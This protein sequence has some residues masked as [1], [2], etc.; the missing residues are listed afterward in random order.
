M[1]VLPVTAVVSRR[2]VAG[3]E[4][5]LEEWAR[6]IVSAA[7][8]FPGHLGAQI[9]PPG[10]ERDDLV[11]AFSFASADD[12]SAWERSEVRLAWVRRADG[13]VAGPATTHALSGLESIFAAPLR[14]A[15]PPPRWKT[16]VVIALALYPAS[17]VLSWL[18]APR[19]AD[20][21]LW[22][23]VLLTVVLVVPW[24][25]WLGVPWVSRALKPWLHP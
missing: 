4:A 19:V 15:S 13:L 7:T 12:L 24:M 1:Q 17:F 3:R 16:A 23:R 5:E 22:L 14:A 8:A 9:Y 11:L 10:P 25:T 18:V 21:P 6:G 20:Q 2:P